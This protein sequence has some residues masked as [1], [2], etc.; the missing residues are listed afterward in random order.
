MNRQTLLKFSALICFLVLCVAVAGC[1]V[2]PDDYIEVESL[3]VEEATI[4]L[5]PSGETS[6]YQLNVEFLPE[7]ATNR[8]LRYYIPSQYLDYVTVDNQGLVTAKMQPEEG[9]RI[10]LT[11]TSASNKKASLVI[12]IIIEYAEVKEI[13]FKQ[14]NLELFW[15]GEPLQLE[16]EYTPYHAQDGR[17][18]TFTSLNP[19]I[20]TVSPNGLLTPLQPGNITVRAV[21]KTMAGKEREAYFHA[22][23][24]Y[25]PSNYRLEV[26]DPSPKY[27]YTVGNTEKKIV[28]NLVSLEPN[29]DPNPRIQWYVGG[30]RITDM[31]NKLKFEHTPASD[32]PTNYKVAVKVLCKDE[33]E[34]TF[35]SDTI[36]IYNQFS[37]FDFVSDNE[38]RVYDNYLYNEVVTFE[39]TSTGLGIDHFN[40]Y[41]RR[42]GDER[43]GV[44][45]GTTPATD[46]NLTRRLNLDGDYA[47]TAVGCD[48]LDVAIEG[49]G[50][51]FNFNVTRYV[52]GDTIVLSPNVLNGGIPPESYNYYLYEC[53]EN[54]NIISDGLYLSDTMSNVVRKGDTIYYKLT[55]NIGE[56]IVILAK[57]MLEGIVAKVNGADFTYQT[58]PIKIY[59]QDGFITVSRV[60]DILDSDDVRNLNYVAR[61]DNTITDLIIDGVYQSGQ[62]LPLVYWSAVGGTEF[63]FVEVTK[64]NGEVLLLDSTEDGGFGDYHCVIPASFVT[65]KD[66]FSV[67]VKQ[68]GG[69][70]TPYY[71]YGYT[72]PAGDN[73]VYY[74]NRIREN[75]YAYLAAFTDLTDNGYIRSIKE[76]GAILDYILL[77]EPA[78]GANSLVSV[79]YGII[80]QTENG[81]ERFDRKYT[82]KVY[83]DVNYDDYAAYYPMDGDLS[84]LETVYINLFKCLQSAQNAY[85]ET[86]DLRVNMQY[87]SGDG[88]YFVHLYKNQNAKTLK[89]PTVDGNPSSAHSEHY[90]ANPYGENSDFA[91]NYKVAKP[92]YTTDQLYNIAESGRQPVAQNEAVSRVYN[93]AKQVVN[94][95]IGKG[96]SDYEKV[97]AFYDWLVLNVEYDYD[98]SQLIGE[99]GDD[100]YSYE[101]FHLE[102]VFLRKKAVCDGIAKAMSLLCR[103]EGIPCYKVSGYVWTN[104]GT[105]HAW[106]K[107]YIDGKWYI[108]DAT[109]G[110]TTLRGYVNYKHFMMTDEQF[111]SYYT[112]AGKAPI[113]YG[114]REAAEQVYNYYAHTFINGRDLYIES[115]EELTD[116]FDSFAS[117]ITPRTIQIR[118]SEVLLKQYNHSL[119]AIIGYAINGTAAPIEIDE[120][121][122]SDNVVAAITVKPIE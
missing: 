1:Q 3:R 90:S 31:D 28:F 27:R 45:V 91:I 102:G 16:I 23:I 33:P 70:Y 62:Y 14:N 7:N 118:V 115:V 19:E 53:D 103:I 55:R 17:N 97:L 67:R 109:W 68:K 50:Q 73:G 79:S 82:F 56:T 52:E 58:K 39:I 116:L 84:G 72:K 81:Q 74:F 110:A 93:A 121:L 11:V 113:I 87:D 107:V 46:P 85:C 8:K 26:S 13:K 18:V 37:G 95:I 122:S 54:G 38:S 119:E 5:S 96:M 41:L 49:Q 105:G 24:K 21:G 92:A 4:Y 12:G 34:K 75:Q 61:T 114:E 98:V 76:L 60:D 32:T 94:T 6:T 9:T 86:S 59:P 77:Y 64:E 35:E 69:Q 104:G 80:L 71:Y 100:A 40:W 29:A 48:A 78:A 65:L 43:Q 42:L 106:N 112:Y 2:L 47:L 51:A 20:A 108:V 36:Y 10:P 63:Y 88:G 44:F 15:R 83:I 101:A 66:K 117:I 89:P 111:V 22:T 120:A 25:A 30:Q 99:T 57:G